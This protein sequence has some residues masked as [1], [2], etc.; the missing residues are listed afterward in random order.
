MEG[1]KTT[2]RQKMLKKHK[3]KQTKHFV[4]HAYVSAYTHAYMYII[5]MYIYMD[6]GIYKEDFH[7]TNK[8]SYINK[9]EKKPNK[10]P[11]YT[12]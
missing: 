4:L 1:K 9:S 8:L 5:D 10:N 3:P 12:F 11:C 7:I 6:V 2:E